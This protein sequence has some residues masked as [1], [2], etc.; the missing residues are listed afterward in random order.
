[1]TIIVEAVRS[2]LISLELVGAGACLHSIEL[3][4]GF[5]L[6]GTDNEYTNT[7]ESRRRT[8]P[9]S[10]KSSRSLL[11]NLQ[12]NLSNIYLSSHFL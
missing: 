7:Q 8:P 11:N 9:S 10:I 4:H 6:S 3:K 1:M 5:P 12:A 2:C